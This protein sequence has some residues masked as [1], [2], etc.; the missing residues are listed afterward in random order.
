MPKES[1]RSR[2]RRAWWGLPTAPIGTVAAVEQLLSEHAE[3]WK[4][5]TV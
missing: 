2:E 1:S 4:L 5:E 3:W